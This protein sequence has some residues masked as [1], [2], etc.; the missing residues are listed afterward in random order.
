MKKSIALL[1]ILSFII[2]P[3][4][5]VPQV[6]ASTPY[7][8]MG[9][10]I[11][12]NGNPVANAQVD[13]INEEQYGATWIILDTKTTDANGN[14]HFVNVLSN[15]PNFKT[16][17]TYTENGQTFSIGQEVLPVDCRDPGYRYN[18]YNVYDPAELSGTGLRLLMGYGAGRGGHLPRAGQRCH[19]RAVQRTEVLF[20]FLERRL[21]RDAAPGGTLPGLRAI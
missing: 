11:D 17:I 4:T 21:L 8:V 19:L 9:K 3:L 20:L 6:S 5:V 16:L 15:S 18:R 1:L 12:R 10:V 14:F 2:L 7:T 13:L